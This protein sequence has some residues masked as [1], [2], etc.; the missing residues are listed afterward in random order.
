VSVAIVDPWPRRRIIK[1]NTTAE[2]ITAPN[3]MKPPILA[4]GLAQT[5]MAFGFGFSL[6]PV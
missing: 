6:C 3:A 2:T 1:P 5:A 4:T